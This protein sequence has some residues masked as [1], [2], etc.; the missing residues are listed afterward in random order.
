MDL[1]KHE[2]F[3]NADKEKYIGHLQNSAVE[4]DKVIQS[5]VLNQQTESLIF[6]MTIYYNKISRGIV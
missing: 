1:L 3:Q 4:L 2:L 5:I 6:Q